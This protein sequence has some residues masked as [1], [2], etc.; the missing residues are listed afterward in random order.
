MPTP[1]P[2][3]PDRHYDFGSMN[4]WF[5]VSAVALLVITVLMVFFDYRQPWKRL[6][7]EFRER[8]RQKLGREAVDYASTA[9]SSAMPGIGSRR[10]FCVLRFSP[11][12]TVALATSSL[13]P[14]TLTPGAQ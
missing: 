7:A 12:N 5:A 13:M 11:R 2:K 14:V 4:L 8:E 9:A 10:R 3:P 6:Q 1:P